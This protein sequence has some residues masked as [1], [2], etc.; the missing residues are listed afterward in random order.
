M[1]SSCSSGL[2]GLIY[3]TPGLRRGGGGGPAAP[4]RLQCPLHS[5]FLLPLFPLAVSVCL[6]QP[7]AAPQYETVVVTGTYEPLTLDEIDRTVPVLLARERELLLNSIGDLLALDASLD[8]QQ[9]APD[10]VQGDLSIRG[11]N[12]GQT[13]VLLN[14]ERLNDSQSG[15]H[16][17]DIPVP[18]AAIAR[19]EVLSGSGST[20]YG[21]DAVAGAINII[22]QPPEDA[23][24]RLRTAFGN[25]GSNQQSVSM[26]G[27]LGGISEQLVA[28]RDFSDGFM[29]DRDYRNLQFSST[30]HFA[31]RLGS[32][33]VT[34]GYMDHPF[35]ANQFYGDYNSWEDTKT[36]R[37]STRL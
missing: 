33:D 1:E 20:M 15:H 2:S 13:L 12:F 37:K 10:G 34:L 25:F 31:T 18:L 32:G 24:V 6:A 21:S 36:D 16:D 17:M 22:T 30:T 14:G 35:G 11:S 29:P 28:A 3:H 23:E 27:S 9:R 8:L 5:G 26:A 4:Y 7:A 19:V